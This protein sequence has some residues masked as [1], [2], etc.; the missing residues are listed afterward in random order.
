MDK[1]K[2][3]LEIGEERFI[4]VNYANDKNERIRN[5]NKQTQVC[6][7]LTILEIN[8]ENILFNL[9]LSVKQL[10][11]IDRRQPS[12]ETMKHTHIHNTQC[13]LLLLLLTLLATQCNADC[14]AAAALKT[15][16]I[17][18]EIENAQ[19]VI[20]VLSVPIQS[21]DSPCSTMSMSRMLNKMGLQSGND[22]SPSCF[23]TYY[24]QWLESSGARAII[25][26]Y[27]ANASTI[28]TLLDSVN[29]WLFTGGG[30]EQDGLAFNSTYMQTALAI[31]NG[32]L[33]KNDAGIFIPL[34][35]TCQGFQILSLLT[36]MNQSIMQYNAFDSENYSLPLDITQ[37]GH[38]SSRLFSANFAPSEIVNILM[39]EN[40]TL[41]LHHDGVTPDAFYQDPK[42]PLFYVLAS[43]NADRVGKLFVSTI[44]ACG[45]PITATQ[46][47]PERPAFEWK[48]G[49][50]IP[51]SGDAITANSYIGQ[52][53]V[54][55]ARRNNQ[56]FTDLNL[57]ARLSVYSYPIINAPGGEF[58]GSR[59]LV[60][61]W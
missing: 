31:Y 40:V 21:D 35:G 59:W 61:D 18:P 58:T 10:G 22:V 56:S 49:M 34:H 24:F 52:F 45:Y 14:N 41:N 7:L 32:V 20:G 53:F 28:N 30:L 12:I 50:N 44:E 1:T 38:H 4:Y 17:P 39:T 57:W 46:W 42:L 11:K 27:D 2:K 43:T 54:A 55:D 48:Q 9:F 26:P 47:H 19:P 13:T 33:A 8:P 60:V 23:N 29:G 6:C 16:T 3:G 25:V 5:K 51:H 36:S 37:D 15:R